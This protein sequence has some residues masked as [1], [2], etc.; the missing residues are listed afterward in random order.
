[1]ENKLFFIQ[2]LCGLKEIINKKHPCLAPIHK[3]SMKSY[4]IILILL[5]LF[6][7]LFLLMLWEKE[8]E[9]RKG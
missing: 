8:E 1:M 5:F 3:H 2:L 7:F 6:L 4:F 9:D